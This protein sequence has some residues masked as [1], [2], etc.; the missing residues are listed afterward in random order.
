MQREA[1]AELVRHVRLGRI[2]EIDLDG[3]GAQHHVEPHAAHAWHVPQHDGIA[4]LGHDRQVVS[5]LVGPHAEAEKAHAH[6]LPDGLDLFEM[7]AGLGTG[8]VQ[9]LERRA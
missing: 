6:A 3:A 9:I 1:G 5:R 8:L 2:I 7:A 4:A